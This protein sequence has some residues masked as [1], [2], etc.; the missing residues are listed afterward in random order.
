MTT[1]QQPINSGFS[2]AST[3][4]DVIAGIDLSGKVAIVTG[5]YSGLGLET[6]RTLHDAGASVIVPTR[7]RTRAVRALSGL[8]RVEIEDMDLLDSSSITAFAQTFLSS[9]RALHVLVN[10]AGI[11][12]SPLARDSRGYESQFA[13]NHLGHFQL[14]AHLRPALSAARGARVIA[15]SSWGHHYSPVDFDDPHFEHRDY[16]RWRAYGQSKTANIL[17]AVAL[18]ARA[19]S[20]GI[21]AFSL[22]PGA[23]VGTG[24]EKHL[25]A[26]ELRAAGVIDQHGKPVLDPKRG[27]KTVAQGAATSVWCA[28]SPQL[29]DKG[30]VYCENCEVAPLSAQ[31]DRPWKTGDSMHTPGVL[32]YAVNA[33]NAERLWRL[34]EQL[35]GAHLPVH[36]I[37]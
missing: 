11:M 22:H 15:V 14:V 12:A 23:I 31:G 4:A 30:G 9:K 33:E 18:D 19:A 16:D 25:S 29:D 21:R 5:G 10:S 20:E 7:D 6:V 13:T 34:S 26:A 28:T 24:L 2:A 17:F 35:L 32:P 37:D 36:P 1:P 3:T 8:E 27:L